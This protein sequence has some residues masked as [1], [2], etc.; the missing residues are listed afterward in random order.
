[1]NARK[2]ANNRVLMRQW[3]MNFRRCV[4]NAE[5]DRRAYHWKRADAWFLRAGRNVERAV[6]ERDREANA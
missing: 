6:M 5:R 4:E 1:M 3:A 2:P